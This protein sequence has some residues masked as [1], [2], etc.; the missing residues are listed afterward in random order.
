LRQTHEAIAEIGIGPHQRQDLGD[1]EFIDESILE[2]A[3]QPLAS[4]PGLRRIGRDVFNAEPSQRPSDLR[5]L[6]LGH[7]PLG[8]R[9]MQQAP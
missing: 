4:P 6:R 2:G 5:Q 8:L 3:I 9:R 7:P 1:A